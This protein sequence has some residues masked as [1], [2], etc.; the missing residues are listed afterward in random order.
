[1][2]AFSLGVVAVMAIGFAATAGN[3]AAVAPIGVGG[4]LRNVQRRLGIFMGRA[5]AALAN[6]GGS[7]GRRGHWLLLIDLVDDLDGWC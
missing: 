1:M 3:L 7:L 5:R 6:A 4:W 2:P